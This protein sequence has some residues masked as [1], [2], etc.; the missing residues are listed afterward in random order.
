[1]PHYQIKKFAINRYEKWLYSKNDFGLEK[2]AVEQVLQ[3]D[4]TH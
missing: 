4:Y 2:I 3:V 1:M